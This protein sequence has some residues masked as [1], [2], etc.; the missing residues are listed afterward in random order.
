[1]GRSITP[2]YRIQ[3]YYRQPNGQIVEVR[4]SWTISSNNKS[5]QA[6]GKPTKENAEK[7]IQAYNNSLKSDGA[8]KHV[9]VALGFM[10]MAHKAE[11][12]NQF[13]GKVVVEWKAPMFQVI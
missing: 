11:I 9:S 7:Y 1:M 10:P 8:N 13:T 4:A 6:D 12:V 5:I 2:K 3:Y